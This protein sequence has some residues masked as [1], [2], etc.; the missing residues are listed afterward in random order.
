VLLT[1]L[2]AAH[3][4]ISAIS[5]TEGTVG[6]QVTVSG[7][8][9]GEKQ[10]AVM[11]GSEKCKILAWTD[12]SI[13]CLITKPQSP[14]YYT[15]TVTDQ[16][17]KKISEPMTYSS[18]IMRK[19]L[20]I[21]GEAPGLA[22]DGDI[23]TINGGFFGDK[24][25][26][27]DLMAFFGN[28]LERAKVV[29]W[30]MDSIR[31]VIPRGLTGELILIVRN[32]VG[33]N[34]ALLDISGLPILQ[35]IPEPTGYGR[36]Y[37]DVNTSGIYYK[38][39]FYVFSVH[40]NEGWFGDYNDRIQVRTFANGKLS[41][42]LPIVKGE[43]W[44]SIV[45]LVVGEE[46][47]PYHKLWVFH[48]S[49]DAR[50]LYTTYDGTNWDTVWHQ[51][52]GGT[53]NCCEIA[54][55]YNPVTH[56]VD[57]YYVKS[58]G[59]YWVKSDNYG[60]TWTSMG[61]VLGVGGT[62]GTGTSGPPSAVF[63]NPNN[64]IDTLDTLLAIYE[65]SPNQGRV[66][67]IKDGAVVGNAILSF[68]AY[69]CG[70]PFLADLSPDSIALMYGTGTRECTP[71][72]RKMDK[73]N[74]Q[75]HDPYQALALPDPGCLDC[76]YRFVWPPNGAINYVPNGSGG[77]DRVFNLFYGYDFTAWFLMSPDGPY[78][79]MDPIENLGH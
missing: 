34:Y 48:T 43:T 69:V 46:N 54:A 35:D 38:G 63:Y 37:A 22:L 71:M 42:T 36:E 77:Y 33:Q 75:W 39:K 9:F 2:S 64:S 32:E 47:S 18:F 45:P 41:G 60:Q 50:I 61:K 10:G 55:V 14:G 49:T 26:D 62:T 15:V 66:Y 30:G 3:A 27:V 24:K 73:A 8:G 76:K 21:P 40:Q 16:G 1:F 23:A 5:P 52:P 72:I 51:V 79:M 65:D 13:E 68:G 7:S 11:V 19:P 31:F 57:V 78:W 53:D 25:G 70:R 29:N 17:N 28:R 4:D 12:D 56:R 44:D 67:G 59:L 74:D 6:T 20:I 58:G